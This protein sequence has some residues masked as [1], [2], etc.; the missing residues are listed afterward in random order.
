MPKNKK[1]LTLRLDEDVI[2][3]A[4]VLAVR[5][6]MSVS[7]LLARHVEESVRAAD[8]YEAAKRKALRTIQRGFSMGGKHETPR[9]ELHDR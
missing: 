5:E 3:Q 9:E 2:Q 8:E 7:A 1:N 4:K 6:G